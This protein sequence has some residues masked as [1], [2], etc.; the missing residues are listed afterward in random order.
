MLFLFGLYSSLWLILAG[1][2]PK[3]LIFGIP[4]VTL[5]IFF[6]RALGF[7]PSK[8][9]TLTFLEFFFTFLWYSLKG[10]LDVA[11][12]VLGIKLVV[13]PGFVVYRL[14]SDKKPARF[15][16]AMV[17]NLTPGTLS[18]ELE[19]DVLLIHLL[20]VK[21]HREEQ[22]KRLEELINRLLS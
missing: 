11:R 21:S 10:G 14:S 16:L 6:H 2:S 19:K 9:R 15:L 1:L 17:L 18:V 7:Y 12:R 8:V 22:I 3:S 13:D 5:A 4:A 20:D